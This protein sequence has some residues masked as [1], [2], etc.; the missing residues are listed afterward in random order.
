MEKHLLGDWNTDVSR[1]DAPMYKTFTRLCDDHGL[2]Q[3]IRQ[4]TRVTETSQTII[5]LVV[6]SDQS[7]IASSGTIVC[8]LSDHYMIFCTR[9]KQKTKSEGHKTIEIRDL[10]TYNSEEFNNKL[11][12]SDWSCVFACTPS[13]VNEAL[14]SFKVGVTS[15]NMI[16]SAS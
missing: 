14:L 11:A 5:D 4:P 13:Q 6:T 1:K 7:M 10:K 15:R 2:T 8:G 16:I 9:K 3:L 12:N